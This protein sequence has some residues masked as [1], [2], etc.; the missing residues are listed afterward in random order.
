[1]A[2]RGTDQANLNLEIFQDT[3]VTYG[4]QTRVLAGCRIFVTNASIRHHGGVTIF[5]QH[6]PPQHKI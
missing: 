1:M 3:K 6:P 2:L 5:Y 4:V